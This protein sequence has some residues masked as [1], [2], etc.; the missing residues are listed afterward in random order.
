[1]QR[2]Q[3]KNQVVIVAAKAKSYLKPTLYIIGGVVLLYGLIY[4]FTRKDQIPPDMKATIDSLVKANTELVTKQKQLD[5]AIKVY[6]VE[7]KQVDDKIDHIKE[8]TT[9]IKEYYHEASQAASTYTPTQVDSFF[10]AR[11]GY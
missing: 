2:K 9:V 1:M 10:K 7:V 8:K 5:S 3:I 4:L 6:E 11:Y